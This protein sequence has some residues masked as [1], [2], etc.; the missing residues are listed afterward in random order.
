[1]RSR[2]C[3]IVLL[4]LLAAALG[5]CSRSATP[6]ARSTGIWGK[7]TAGP[8]CP[9][10]QKNSPCPPGVWTGTVR[11]T[12]AGGGASYEVA[13]DSR[14]NYTLPLPPGTY[15][16]MPE[17]GGGPLPMGFPISETV[18]EGRMQKLD[19]QVDTGIR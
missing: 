13:T 6:S 15:E 5:A 4:V 17:T 19:M 12:A 2:T 14:G 8:M 11:A 7:V 16:V 10:E 3:A 9:A 1:M 18:K